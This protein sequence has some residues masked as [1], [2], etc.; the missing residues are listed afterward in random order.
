M[1]LD[2]ELVRRNRQPSA[3]S[4]GALALISVLGLAACEDDNPAPAKEDA[5]VS[6]AGDAAAPVTVDRYLLGSLVFGASEEDTSS[7]VT[8]VDKLDGQDVD[9][10]QSRE[11]PGNGD[12]WLFNGSVYVAIAEGRTI[13]RY[14]LDGDELV[15]KERLDFTEYGLSSFGF[16]LNTFI[17]P[18]KAYFVNGSAEYIVW[19]PTT[20]QI[21]K[22]IDLP[23]FEPEDDFL[24]QGGYIDRAAVRRGK[25]FLQPFYF[26][27]AD[28]FDFQPSSKI[29]VVD[30]EKD[31]VV[32]TLDAPCP[33]LDFATEDDDGNA[34]LS[35]WIFAPGGAAVLDSPATCVVKIPAG[36]EL[37]VETA[38]KVS[39]IADGREGG[40]FRYL[41]NDRAILSVLHDDRAKDE[42]KELVADIA[43]GAY[44][45]FW[46]YDLKTK[47]ATE[48]TDIEWNAGAA[49]ATE[50]SGKPFML[51]P[52]GD[53]SETLVY[54]LSPTA[55]PKHVLT[56]GGWALRLFGVE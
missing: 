13:T 12:V 55:T 3:A 6:D 16:W 42:G 15:E 49:Y 14:T 46:S 19:N 41:G 34:Y 44:W 28:Y 36:S 9:Y 35:S 17:S 5:A 32:E 26:A 40:V 52:A 33:G 20:M 47:K 21:D 31:E 48:V 25:F 54:E 38:F 56:A 29:V 4:I 22:T 39:D 51:V 24:V 8:L 18:T 23:D 30:T 2:Y 10:G 27:D 11:F 7:Y 53:Y 1:K 37:K 50:V 43:Y 45:R